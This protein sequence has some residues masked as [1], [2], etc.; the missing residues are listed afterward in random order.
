MI[1][2]EAIVRFVQKRTMKRRA[3][4]SVSRTIFDLP[5][6]GPVSFGLV[7]LPTPIARSKLIRL[8]V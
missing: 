6:A 3:I 4:V 7:S 5:L 1:R 8:A 2:Y